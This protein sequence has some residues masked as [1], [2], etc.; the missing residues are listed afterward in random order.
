MNNTKTI[1]RDYTEGSLLRQLLTFAVPFMLSALLQNL[2]NMVDTIVVGQYVGSAGISGVSVGGQITNLMTNLVMGFSTAGQVMVSRYVGSKSYDNLK[3]TMGTLFSVTILFAL[4]LTAFC[5]LF[6]ATLLRW[7]NT[8]AEAIDQARA[9]LSICSVGFVFVCGYNAACAVLRGSGDSRRPFVIIAATSVT[10]LALDLLFVA[11]FRMEAAG[12]AIATVFSQAVSMVLAV[13]ILYRHRDSYRFSFRLSS[14]RP[15]AH[16]LR[17]L[18]RQGIPLALKSASISLSAL[19]INSFVNSFGV[20]ASAAIAVGNKLEHLPSIVT[21]GLYNAGTAMIGQ[22]VGAGRYDRVKKL[23]RIN[24]LCCVTVFTLF[25]VGFLLFPEAVFRLF[26]S[27]E[28]VLAYA[29]AF[30]RVMLVAFTASALMCPFYSVVIG[31]GNAAFNLVIS[32]LDGIVLRIGLGLLFGR[33]LGMGV[34]GFFLGSALAA[35]GTSIPAMIYYF[36]G[37]WKTFKL[38]K[39]AS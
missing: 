3:K 13:C 6:C 12:A 29:P 8:P 25:G 34:V 7:M 24:L 33:V 20:V 19:F 27:E 9:Y 5:E 22:N 37:R 30:V 14:F 2:Y 18:V 38:D 23:V 39:K 26:T 21:Q 15:D 28:E 4:A 10:N 35:F 1:I 32:L 17:L 36:T 31:I 11:V 16:E